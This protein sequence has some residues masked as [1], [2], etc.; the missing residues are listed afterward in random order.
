MARI[1]CSQTLLKVRTS[2]TPRLLA[3]PEKRLT[4]RAARILSFSIRRIDEYYETISRRHT[5]RDRCVDNIYKIKKKYVSKVNAH[6]CTHNV[7]HAPLSVRSGSKYFSQRRRAA[8]LSHSDE[9][10]MQFPGFYTYI[11]PG[12]GRERSISI[13][14]FDEMKFPGLVDWIR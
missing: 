1:V 12:L 9:M 5:R 14:E 7:V 10:K 3:A 4:I 6:T 13:Q 8:R 2:E 11:Y